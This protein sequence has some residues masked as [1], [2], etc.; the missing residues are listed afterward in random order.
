[1]KWIDNINNEVGYLNNKNNYVSINEGLN[2]TALRVKFQDTGKSIDDYQTFIV[3]GNHKKTINTMN[4]DLEI[5]EW[6]AE[7]TDGFW[8]NNVELLKDYISDNFIK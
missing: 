1:M 4:S 6:F 8:S 3:M 2:E 5:M 7:K